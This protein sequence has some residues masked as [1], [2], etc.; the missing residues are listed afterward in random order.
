MG[1]ELSQALSKQPAGRVLGLQAQVSVLPAEDPPKLR[2]GLGSPGTGAVPAA[3]LQA[4]VHAGSVGSRLG[5][6]QV[7]GGTQA[8]NRRGLAPGR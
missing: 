4:G 1:G 7:P 2:E 5:G 3:L 6:R 8:P